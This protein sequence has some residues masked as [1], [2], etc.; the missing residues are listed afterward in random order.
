MA[1]LTAPKPFSPTPSPKPGR[2][3]LPG[4]SAYPRVGNACPGVFKGGEEP[5]GQVVSHV[6]QLVIVVLNRHVAE[7]LLGV[8]YYSVGREEAPQDPNDRKNTGKIKSRR[9]ETHAA[10]LGS[11][12]AA[13]GFGWTRSCLESGTGLGGFWKFSEALTGTAES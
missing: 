9:L 3:R 6:Q 11:A 8:G 1:F 2:Q 7:G 4:R 13:A 12:A 5:H 10:R